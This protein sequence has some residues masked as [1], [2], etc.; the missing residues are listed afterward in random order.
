MLSENLVDDGIEYLKK[1][2]I[3][4]EKMEVKK[5]VTPVLLQVCK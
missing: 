4:V 1:K 5:K 3:K 2:N